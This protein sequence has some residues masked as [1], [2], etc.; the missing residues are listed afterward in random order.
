MSEIDNQ[1]SGN[2]KEKVLTSS[3]QN[4]LTNMDDAEDFD[5]ETKCLL[6]NP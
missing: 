6:P 5:T 3:Y 1:S 4:S 2:A